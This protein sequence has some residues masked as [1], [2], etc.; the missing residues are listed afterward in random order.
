MLNK[1]ER[2]CEVSVRDLQ[3]L[4]TFLYG[5]YTEYSDY[6]KCHHKFKQTIPDAPVP[7][8]KTI[9]KYEIYALLRYYVVSC[10]NCLP[11]F[12]DNMSVPSSRVKNLSRKERKPATYN[13]DSGKYVCGSNQ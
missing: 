9:Y 5:T 4:C 12:L 7:H 6:K 1:L 11:T 13:V 8:S 3:S 10:G 2:G